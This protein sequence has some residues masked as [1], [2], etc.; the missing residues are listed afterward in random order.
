[1]E[2]KNIIFPE[3]KKQKEGKGKIY[4]E[5]ENIFLKNGE[6]KEEIFGKGNFFADE[7]KNGQGKGGK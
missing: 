6:E 4:S 2:N 3:E 7:K 5:M 1:M